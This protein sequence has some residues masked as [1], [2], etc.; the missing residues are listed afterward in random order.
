MITLLC[1][2]IAWFYKNKRKNC[3]KS[4]I[5]TLDSHDRNA[6][7]EEGSL[8]DSINEDEIYDDNI[9][10]IYSKECTA[11]INSLTSD[12]NVSSLKSE[13]SDYLHPYTTVTKDIET[14]TYCTQI[15][16]YDSSSSSSASDDMK[17][18]SGYTHPYQNLEAVKSGESKLEYSKLVQY[19]EFTDIPKPASMSISLPN[20]T[21]IYRSKLKEQKE[22]DVGVLCSVLK[23]NQSPCVINRNI[24]A[25]SRSS[26]FKFHLVRYFSSVPTFDQRENT[27]VDNDK[28]S[29]V[30]HMSV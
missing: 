4:R 11:V 15:K 21:N 27:C 18:D 25:S 8:Y 24:I 19:F 20:K 28:L 6:N 12:S 22:Y 5:S 17:R 14:H 29:N 10:I 3:D 23:E 30:K 16:S 7:E 9:Q 2:L 1:F 13:C 26:D